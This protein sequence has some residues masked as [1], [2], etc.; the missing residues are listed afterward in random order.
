MVLVED[1]LAALQK[2]AAAYLDKF[3]GLMRV[4]ITG[5]NGKTTTKELAAA[6]LGAQ[7][8]VVCNAGNLNSDIG[9]PLSVFKVRPSHEAGIFEAGMNRRGEISELAAVLR[10]HIAL[11]TN[12]GSAH[13]GIIGTR[14]DIALEKKALFAHFS[15]NET[16]LIPAD[17]TFAEFL[18]DGVS[19]KVIY[20]GDKPEGWSV[21]E[22]RGLEGWLLIGGDSPDVVYRLPGRH[23]LRNAAAAAAIARAA[24]VSQR[25]IAAG[26]EAA[27]PLFGRGE[28]M[29]GRIT[30]VQDCY[31]SSPES[32]NEAIALSDSLAW[33]GKRHYVFGSMLELGKESQA[34]HEFLGER[35]AASKADTVFLFGEET[36][37][38]MK[39]LEAVRGLQVFH[40]NDADELSQKLIGVLREG[41]MVLL[42][43]SRACKMESIMGRL[44]AAGWL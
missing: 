28:I 44:R 35:L 37:A 18:A 12:V 41:D 33:H 29:R 25:G 15:G 32:A 40:T 34:A 7:M 19:G 23:N 8:P 13:I 4:G 30:L 43:G 9:L 6:M 31:N 24:G 38:A 2:A 36:Q 42:K 27:R 14:R 22:D 20:Y 26:L 10:P 17:D 16:A 5:S 21:A 3:P 1:T 39:K 11:I